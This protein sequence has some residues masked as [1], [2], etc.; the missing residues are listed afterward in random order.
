MEEIGISYDG[1]DMDN[2]S[3]DTHVFENDEVAYII[4]KQLSNNKWGI[5]PYYYDSREDKGREKIPFIYDSITF[6]KE[7]KSKVEVYRADTG[8]RKIIS[9]IE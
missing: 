9:L 1:L 5:I 2:V 3:Y 7:D 6:V 8:E 4:V